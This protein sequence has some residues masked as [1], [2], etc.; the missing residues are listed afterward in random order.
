MSPLRHEPEVFLPKYSQAPIRHAGQLGKVVKP[1]PLLIGVSC[2]KRKCYA[3][4]LHPSCHPL[5]FP[6]HLPTAR[7]YKDLN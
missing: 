2:Q 3:T 5:P 6:D 1:Q 7:T 4:P